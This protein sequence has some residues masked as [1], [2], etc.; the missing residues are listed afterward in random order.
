MFGFAPIRGGVHPASR[1]DT[2]AQRD[3]LTRL[4]L[5]ARLFLPLFQQAGAK[6]LPVVRIGEQVA[7]GQCIAVTG[8]GLSSHLHAPTSGAIVAFEDVLAP[9]PS[10]LSAPAIILEPDGEER[11]HAPPRDDNPFDRS[12]DALSDEVEKAG[13]VGLGGAVFPSAL[14][15]RQGR[16][17]EIRTLVINGGECEPYLT[18]DDRLMRERAAAI[19][20]GAR[21]IQ[22]IVESYEIVIGIED[23]KPEAIAGWARRSR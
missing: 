16:R 7:K 12:P 17:Y 3:I 15:L 10:G 14:K 11:W 22:H 8:V 2:T 20:E 21:L 18:T 13:I 4:P 1:K 19:V 9:H 6:S 23:N 5:P